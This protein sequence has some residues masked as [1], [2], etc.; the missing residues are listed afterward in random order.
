[1]SLFG[2]A[3]KSLREHR[4]RNA[5][6]IL[7]VAVS[8]LTF[9]LLR[10]VVWAW[11]VAIEAAAPDRIATRHKVTFVM[12]LPKKYFHEIEQVDAVA[13]TTFAVW[14]DARWPG[15]ERE[16]FAALAVNSATFLDV[17]DEVQVDPKAKEAWLANRKGALVGAVLAKKLGWKA[18]DRVRLTSGI[19][20]DPGEWEFVIEGIYDA[21][22]KSVDRSMFL[23]HF[24]YLNES[25][26]EDRRDQVGWIVSRIEDP[27]QTTE[28]SK[29]IDE[30]FD[31]QDTQ[32]LTMSEG[33]LQ[34]SFLGMAAAVL[35]AVDIVSIAILAIMMLI[36]GNTIAMGVRDRTN[37]YAA[38][39]AIGF[40]PGHILTAVL[41]EGLLIGGLGGGLGLL[42]AYPFI[43]QLVGR[44]IEENMGAYFPYFRMTPEA[45]ATA[46]VIAV[47]LGAG[48]AA[49]PAR[50]ASRLNIVDALRKVG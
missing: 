25:I 22:R 3:F 36:L 48:A 4:L 30:K 28:V 12:T 14:S 20:P 5:L 44:F 19:Y 45:A 9:V 37:Q 42:L 29:R 21:T 41:S 31:I 49:L 11:T 27:S 43:N 6:T 35:R 34:K 38:M 16:F 24:D 50:N 10:T 40:L 8:I 2:L 13:A 26:P 47:A 17:Y 32:T 18:G 15:N 7:A 33:D 39:R 23:W 1:M 46:L